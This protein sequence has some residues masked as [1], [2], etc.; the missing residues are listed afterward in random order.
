MK[1]VTR[2]A[3]S[4]TGYMHVGNFRTAL[5]N[6]F[7]ARQQGGEFILRIEDTDRS[8]YVE[9]AVEALFHV[10]KV[11]GLDFDRTPYVQS[12]RLEIYQMHVQKLIEQG[13]AYYC[14]CPKERLEAVRKEQMELK[15]QTKY[16]QTC[17]HL[18][19]E[20][21]AQ[22][23]AGNEPYV[24]RLRIPEGKT[25]FTD[26][27]RGEITIDNMEIDDQVL[28]KTDGFPTY[29]LAVVVDDNDM[30]VTHVIRAEEWISSVPKHIILYKAFGFN[31]PKFA[32]LPLV[33]NPDKSKLSKRQGD[34]A[35]EDY[36]KKG[37]LPEALLNFIA[38][39][40]FNPTADREIYTKEELI[41]LFDLS[42]IN[43]SGAVFDLQKLNWVNE[44]YLKNKTVQELCEL[45]Q[46][47]LGNLAQT[48][49]P[50]FIE[51]ICT[52]E[53]ERMTTLQDIPNRISEYL[54]RPTY[55]VKTL[56]WKK[57]DVMDTKNQLLAME[58]FVFAMAENLFEELSL[59]E[60]TIK[61]YIERG[62]L[63][64]GNVLWPLRVALS[65]KEHSPSPFELMW[66]LGKEESLKR[67]K[68]AIN[69]FA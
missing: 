6:Y 53:Q 43:K 69:L 7:Y 42:K 9:G 50:I 68:S 1:V 49:N 16:D 32:H 28:M 26:E 36:L 44:Q 67:I 15:Q 47:F 4:P 58:K 14:F 65:G 51:K 17:A 41:R 23:L 5:Y 56:V 25:T 63:K 22:K 66:I 64:T 20:D 30:G 3:P 31:I 45:V 57:S 48:V 27:I 34:V 37:Y 35:V 60:S 62:G 19:K 59:I 55:D 11:M 52:I 38:L 24:I 46:P 29:H 18:L 13:S 12:E 40:G 10:L 8:R 39:L 33:L 21:I 54:E 61:T 2:I